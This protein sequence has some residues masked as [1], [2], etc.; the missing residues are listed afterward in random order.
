MHRATRPQPTLRSRC[1][2][3]ALSCALAAV[4]SSTGC[5]PEALPAFA[6]PPPVDGSANPPSVDSGTDAALDAGGGAAD[7]SPDASSP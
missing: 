4:S 7:A 3:F 2:H 5:G 6:N 1:I